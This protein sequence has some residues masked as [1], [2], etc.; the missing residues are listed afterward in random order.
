VDDTIV[1]IDIAVVALDLLFGVDH[2]NSLSR[3]LRDAHVREFSTVLEAVA[4]L[5]PGHPA[6]ILVGPSPEPDP[7]LL[8]HVQQA[9][10]GPEVGIVFALDEPDSDLGRSIHEAL[11]TEPLGSFDADAIDAAVDAALL[12][13]R[14]AGR[15]APRTS[16]P[17]DFALTTGPRDE[18]RLIVVTGGAGGTGKTT[19]ALNL[20][21]A[22]GRIDRGRVALIDAHKT[23]GDIELLL[24]FGRRDLPDGTDIEDFEIDAAS[25]ARLLRTHE[26]TQLRVF[27]PPSA[28]TSL[29]PLS[30][31]QTLRL[32]V[33]LEDQVD[34]AVIDAP[35]ELVDQASLQQFCDALLLVTTN[36]L[37]SIK[38]TL[39]ARDLLDRHPSL[40]VVTNDPTHDRGGADA[41]SIEDAVQLRV[42]SALPWDESIDEGAAARP[43]TGLSRAGT[44]FTKRIEQLAEHLHEHSLVR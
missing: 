5:T 31:E 28:A 23:T 27:S 2:L 19:V 25:V 30:V 41:G 10:L 43:A 8:A 6:V 35:L 44:G 14:Q 16:A 37:P 18:L 32:L 34:T 39:V 36:R 1:S 38:N 11:G 7:D 29:A 9:N 24:G 15:R 3:R 21:A 17:T 12:S 40:A 22:L 33:A 4:H 42:L 13:R 26:A 20:A